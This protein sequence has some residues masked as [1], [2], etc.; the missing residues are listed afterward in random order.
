VI[1]VVGLMSVRINHIYIKWKSCRDEH[2]L[3]NL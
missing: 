3:S 2:R 1:L